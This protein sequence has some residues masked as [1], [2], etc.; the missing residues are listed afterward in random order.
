MKLEPDWLKY[1]RRI[2]LTRHNSKKSAIARAERKRKR[3]HAKKFNR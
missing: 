1:A 2:A 3:N